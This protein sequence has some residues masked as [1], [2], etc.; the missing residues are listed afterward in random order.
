MK[1]RLEAI[2]NGERKVVK[3]FKTRDNAN[4]Y[5]AR[6]MEQSNLEINE[7]VSRNRN[8]DFEF[9]CDDYNRVFINRV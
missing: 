2:L 7:I 9:I 5:L 3:K 4:K 6:L 8:H 1:Y